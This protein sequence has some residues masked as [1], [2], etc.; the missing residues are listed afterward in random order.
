MM[1]FLT[2]YFTQA[3]NLLLKISVYITIIM[4]VTEFLKNFKIID[5]LNNKLY[6]LTKYLGISKAANYPLV[7][8][9]IVGVTYGAG[10]IYQSY[11][12]G[13]MNKKDVFLVCTFLALA[14]AIIEDTM[15]F[16]AFGANIIVIFGFR[17][18]IAIIVTIMASKF[19]KVKE[20]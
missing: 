18:I 10:I 13:E 20:K 14:H 5:Y 8:G 17:T 3:F 4:V 15:L 7:F 1:D 6:P 16:A 19:Y 11:K 12:H 9:Y 2:L